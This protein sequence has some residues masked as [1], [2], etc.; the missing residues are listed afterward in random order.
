[1][2]LDLV[3]A[4]VT[5]EIQIHLKEQYLVYSSTILS[6]VMHSEKADLFQ[7][8]NGFL[9]DLVIISS[10]SFM[11]HHLIHENIIDLKTFI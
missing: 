6:K 3:Q 5:I 8:Y 11:F 4:F 2:V 10:V 1:M 7:T 9:A